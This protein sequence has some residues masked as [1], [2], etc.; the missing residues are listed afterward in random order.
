MNKNL[1]KL[2]QKLIEHGEYDEF[3]QGMFEHAEGKR[4][5]LREIK[6]G[7]AQSHD[8]LYL[9]LHS[10]DQDIEEHKKRLEELR[11]EYTDL[12]K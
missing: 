7:A 4:D 8:G 9:Y 10:V 12:L 5:F 1:E 3:A 11:A 2:K 6:N